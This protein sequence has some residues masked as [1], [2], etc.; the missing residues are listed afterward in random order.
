M[1]RP[2]FFVQWSLS[3]NKGW[4]WFGGNCN[5]W[6]K[7]SVYCSYS[8]FCSTFSEKC[9]AYYQVCFFFTKRRVGSKFYFSSYVNMLFKKHFLVYN[10]LWICGCWHFPSVELFLFEFFC[11]KWRDLQYEKLFFLFWCVFL[12]CKFSNEDRKIKFRY[13]IWKMHPNF[14]ISHIWKVSQFSLFSLNW[15]C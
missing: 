12:G 14:E 13:F 2:S 7:N 9:A 11:I 6:P 1:W 15:L 4:D 10:M 8:F 5:D 3:Q